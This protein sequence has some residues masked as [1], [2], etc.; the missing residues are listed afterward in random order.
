MQTFFRFLLAF[1][2]FL[3]TLRNRKGVAKRYPLT[4]GLFGFLK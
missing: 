1:R 2:G 4:R 3:Q